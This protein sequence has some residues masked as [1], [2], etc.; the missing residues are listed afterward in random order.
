MTTEADGKAVFGS[1]KIF[2][3]GGVKVGVFGL[4][5]PE[6]LTKADASKMPGIT[7]PPDRPPVRRRPGSGR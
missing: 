5:T 2:E 7:F 1:N 6:T 4:A 3:I